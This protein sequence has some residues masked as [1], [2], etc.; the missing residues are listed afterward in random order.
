MLSKFS[1]LFTI[2]LIA[3]TATV[4]AKSILFGQPGQQTML[5]HVE[6]A[7]SDA[8]FVREIAWSPDG[9]TI[10]VTV[11]NEVRLYNVSAQ[12]VGRLQGHTDKVLSIDWHASNR[13]VSTGLDGTVRIWNM[14]PGSNYASL[15]KVF[16]NIIDWNYTIRWNPAGT[17]LAIRTIDHAER[18]MEA[19][20]LFTA[21]QIWNVATEQ[22]E[23][24]L[25]SFAGRKTLD[26]SPDGTRIAD[27]GIRGEDSFAARVWDVATGDMIASFPYSLTPVSHV[28]WNSTGQYLAISSDVSITRIV[29]VVLQQKLLLI[30]DGDGPIDW[31]PDDTMLVTT[32]LGGRIVISDFATTQ[33]MVRIEGAHSGSIARVRWS[34][35]GDMIATLGDED[36]TLRIWD[37]SSV[38]PLTGV[39]TVTPAFVTPPSPTPTLTP[40]NRIIYSEYVNGFGQ[41][42]TANLDGSN[43]TQL[44]VNIEHAIAPSHSADGQRIVFAGR[45]SWQAPFQ[46]YMADQDGSGVTQM[47]TGQLPKSDPTFEKTGQWIVYSERIAFSSASVLKVT[48]TDGSTLQNPVFLT[49]ADDDAYH[50]NWFDGQGFVYIDRNN[51]Q[52]DIVLSQTNNAGVIQLTDTQ[53]LNES[54][55]R[56][57]PDGSRIAYIASSGGPTSYLKIMNADGTGDFQSIQVENSPYE[58]S[59]DGTQLVVTLPNRTIAIVDSLTGVY[60]TIITD[61]TAKSGVSWAYGQGSNPSLPTATPTPTPT[62][63]NTPAI[64]PTPAATSTPRAYGT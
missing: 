43:K 7:I 53:T 63:S 5:P 16:A 41:L 62:S 49:L 44:S 61:T 32:G 24:T 25:P 56:W 39:A 47:T 15:E 34:P 19:Y 48:N 18:P 4:S 27:S 36:R 11:E 20:G 14:T 13:L 60:I 38:M 6:V 37:V 23:M 58:W 9:T 26:W 28:A 45:T 31:S 46:I 54:Y 8:E 35:T 51:G 55:P 22:L 59:P 64:T 3:L 40:I 2:L 33:S 17:H 57:S 12:E 29:D 42:F 30:D 21:I 10:A 1:K 52:A 50:G